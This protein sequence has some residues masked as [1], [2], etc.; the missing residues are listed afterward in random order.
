MVTRKGETLSLFSGL[1][2][3]LVFAIFSMRW[4]SQSFYDRVRQETDRLL[5][6][7]ENHSPEWKELPP[8]KEMEEQSASLERLVSRR[9]A[10]APDAYAARDRMDQEIKDRQSLILLSDVLRRIDLTPEYA[11]ADAR[12]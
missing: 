12:N 8:T 11:G 2:S 1:L 10:L 5:S 7:R 9:D 6:A 4:L 3:F